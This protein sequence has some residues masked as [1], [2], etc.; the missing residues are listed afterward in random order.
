M[1]LD[2][3]LGRVMDIPINQCSRGI[4]L[5]VWWS[6]LEVVCHTPPKEGLWRHASQF[7]LSNRLS[8]SV[9]WLSP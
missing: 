2:C 5:N 6:S 1:F 4:V 8:M 3:E 7:H 9:A